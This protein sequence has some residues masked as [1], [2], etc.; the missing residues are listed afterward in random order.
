MHSIQTKTTLLNVIAI[1]VALSVATV[2]SVV[3]VANFGHE[4]SEKTMALQCETSKNNLNYYFKSVEQSVNT[5]SSLINSSLDEVGDFTTTTNDAFL[6][7]MDYAE[8]IFTDSA[9]NANGVLTYYYRIDP[10]ISNLYKGGDEAK[11]QKALGFYY[12]KT[13]GK[14]FEW[15]PP[16]DLEDPNLDLYWFVQPKESKKALWL[17]PYITD[18]LGAYV[19]SYNVPVIHNTKFVGVIGIEISYAMLGEQIQDVRIQKTGYAYIID[20]NQGKIIYHPTIDLIKNPEDKNLITPKKVEEVI[21]S[22]EHHFVYTY[23][24]VEKHAYWLE[25][26]NGMDIVVCVPVSEIHS[27][28]VKLIVEIVIAAVVIIAAFV[29]ITIIYS[30][31][32]TK[33]L[34]DLTKAAE[35]INAGNYTIKLDYHG[36]DEMA[37]LTTTVNKLID[38]LGGYISDLNSLAYSDAL[39]SVRNKSAYDIFEREL[40]ERIDNPEDTPE[41]AI[42]MLDC[43]DLKVIND[44]YG[45]DK[46]DVYLKNSS[47]L[48]CRVFQH[49]PVFRIGGDEFVL[50]LQ[51]EDLKNWEKLRQHFIEKSAEI[52]AFAR[53]PWEKICV[54][55][56]IAVYDP[57]IDKTVEDVLNRADHLMYENKHERKNK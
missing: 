56:G 16:S 41:F 13:N 46:G 50:I 51:N 49:S 14:T 44:T 54:A 26:G 6:A 17:A 3:S 57:K 34:R 29:F 39:T 5:V 25:L 10:S 21:H 1:S 38:H 22:D 8:K 31:H 33:P 4:S 36:D 19:V 32:F 28:W 55:V 47:H 40:Q 30:R 12:E 27:T 53:E 45:H 48:I 2:I 20:N 11:A 24:G 52:T 35:E 42:A 37:I 9:E 7:Q 23:E 43:D 15:Y 18:N